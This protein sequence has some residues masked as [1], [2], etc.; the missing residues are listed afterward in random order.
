MIIADL[1]ESGFFK[2]LRLEVNHNQVLDPSVIE[3]SLKLIVS[4]KVSKIQKQF[5]QSKGEIHE[6]TLINY[7]C[8]PLFMLHSRVGYEDCYPPGYFNF[9][10]A[11]VARSAP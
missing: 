2:T 10:L 11:T 6:V 1:K 9:R 3:L 8:R 5:Q 4:A 7:H